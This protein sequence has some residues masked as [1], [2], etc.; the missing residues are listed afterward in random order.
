MSSREWRCS[1]SS[2]DR[3]CSNYIWVIDNFIAFQG[4]S[5]IRG[6]TVV[7][8]VSW[9]AS[10]VE[11]DWYQCS[12]LSVMIEATRPAN[13]YIVR[14]WPTQFWHYD[15]TSRQ[16]AIFL[17]AIF[18]A[19]VQLFLMET[20]KYICIFFTYLNILRSLFNQITRIKHQGISN[21][22]MLF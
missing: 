21:H 18:I 20:S 1:W 22:R 6:F 8:F 2:A 15:I 5:Y 14:K 12:H 3:R 16:W 4:T 11:P 9:M 19:V 17:F 7:I 10:F 13:I